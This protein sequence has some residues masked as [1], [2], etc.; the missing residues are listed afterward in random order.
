MLHTSSS[1]FTSINSNAITHTKAAI[2]VHVYAV[3]TVNRE[4]SVLI[5][6]QMNY[7]YSKIKSM[8]I[9]YEACVPLI[10]HCRSVL[11]DAYDQTLY[12]VDQNDVDLPHCGAP[13]PTTGF[14]MLWPPR[15]HDVLASQL[16]YSKLNFNGRPVMPRVSK[17]LSTRKFSVS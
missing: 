11:L 16:L 2:H 3:N 1:K 9:F 17:K 10:V 13:S 6:F 15:M 7:W 8:K 5:Y 4:F 14:H 12:N